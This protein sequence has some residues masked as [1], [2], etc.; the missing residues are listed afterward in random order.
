MPGLGTHITVLWNVDNGLLGDITV[1]STVITVDSTII[2]VDE[3]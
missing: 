2:S 3:T 1:D